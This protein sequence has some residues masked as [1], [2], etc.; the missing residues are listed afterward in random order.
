MNIQL[1]LKQYIAAQ[2]QNVASYSGVAARAYSISDGIN[3]IFINAQTKE[4]ILETNIHNIKS[5][6]RIELE[7]GILKQITGIIFQNG[8]KIIGALDGLNTF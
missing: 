6:I 5:N 7:T 2:K 8:I 4:I 1:E 3:S